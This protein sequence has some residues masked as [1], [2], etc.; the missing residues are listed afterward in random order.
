MSNKENDKNI[1]NQIEKICMSFISEKDIKEMCKYHKNLC[2]SS[3]LNVGKYLI[4]EKSDYF[5]ICF[6]KLIKQILK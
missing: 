1:N 6:I 2:M 5:N 4:E 3:G